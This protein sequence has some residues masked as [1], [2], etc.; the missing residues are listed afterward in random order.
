MASSPAGRPDV[1]IDACCLVNFCA[2]DA[3]L[4]FLG[5]FGVSWRLPAAARSEGLYIR[6]QADSTET[7]RIDVEPVIRAGVIEICLPSRPGPDLSPQERDEVKKVARHLLERVRAALVSVI[8]WRQKAEARARVRVAI[9]DTLDDGLPRVYAPE[10]YQK[11]CAVLFEHVFESFGD[12]REAQ[13]T[14]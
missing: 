8:N 9:E 6:V 12:T 2:V 11:K 13:A 1:V 7:V 10:I 4:L 5:E 3:K 14:A